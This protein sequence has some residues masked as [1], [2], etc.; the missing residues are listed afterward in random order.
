[1]INGYEMA[2]CLNDG[3]QFFKVGWTDV[4]AYFIAFGH[5]AN[6]ADEGGTYINVYLLINQKLTN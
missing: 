3:Q 5:V 4:L 2:V 1:M 6:L